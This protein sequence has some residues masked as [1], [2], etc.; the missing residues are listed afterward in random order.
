MFGTHKNKK[1]PNKKGKRKQ[2]YSY[3][4]LLPNPYEIQGFSKMGLTHFT[5]TQILLSISDSS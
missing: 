1:K 3:T 4:Y 2:I 5:L